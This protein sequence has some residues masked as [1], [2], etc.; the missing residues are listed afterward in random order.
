MSRILPSR[1]LRVVPG[2]QTVLRRARRA[3]LTLLSLAIPAA[4]AEAQPACVPGT[5]AEYAAAGF[6]CRIG[7]WVLTDFGFDTQLDE[8][9][10]ATGAG[11][12]ASAV[13]LTP[14]LHHDAAGLA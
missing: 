9:G 14:F 2:S 4:R 8:M 1:L 7:S 11:A 12:A 3:A 6:S 10:G 5:A 13:V